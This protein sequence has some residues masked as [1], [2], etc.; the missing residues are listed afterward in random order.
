MRSS[1]CEAGHCVEVAPGWV[2]ASCDSSACVEAQPVPG[3]VLLRSS[4]MPEAVV[5]V[6]RE[7]W[8]AFVAGVKAGDFDNI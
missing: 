2:R 8:A 7:E 6:T 1:F 4:L 5:D 3:G